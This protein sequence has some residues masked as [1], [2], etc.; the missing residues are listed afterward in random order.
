MPYVPQS[1]LP[2]SLSRLPWYTYGR[3]ESK[4]DFLQKWE[5][6]SVRVARLKERPLFSI[7]ILPNGSPADLRRTIDALISQSYP[8]WEAIVI[9][10]VPLTEGRVRSLEVPPDTSAA[11][12]KNL[13]AD[14]AQGVWLSFLTAGD[15]LSPVALFDVTC[16]AQQDTADVYYCNEV[17]TDSLYT[18]RLH[19]FSKPEASWFTQLHMDYIGTL[20]WVRR[21]L[22]SEIG[23]FSLAAQQD[24][25]FDFVLHLFER[26]VR[27]ELI[28]RF[29]FFHASPF[30]FQTKARHFQQRL[31]STH[32]ER[33]GLPAKT[34]LSNGSISITPE[35]VAPTSHLLSV[36]V[37]FKNKAD[38]TIRSL[39]AL[40]KQKGRVPVEVLLVDNASER[41]E[42]EKL[43]QFLQ[44]FE[45][46][47]RV[48][49]YPEAFNYAHMHNTTVERHVKG[50]FLLLLNNDVFL[51]GDQTLDVL[52]AWAQ[53]HWVGTVGIPLYF[54]DGEIQ[55]AAFQAIPGGD[56]RLAFIT[57]T[58]A[59]FVEQT[60][61]TFGS[62][63][64]ACLMKTS[65]FK[66]VGLEELKYPNAFGDVAFSFECRRKGLK[67]LYLA[68]LRATHLQSKS[69]G[70]NY[71]F[72]EEQA[73]ESKYSDVLQAML[74]RDLGLDRGSN[75]REATKNYVRGL[76]NRKLVTPRGVFRPL[77]WAI[78]KVPR[79]RSAL[80]H[81]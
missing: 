55:H 44:V 73:V 5:E 3:P 1:P 57:Q 34:H 16:M 63:F 12:A 27:F 59:D 58:R 23:G 40:S 69:R 79:L 66:E 81:S 75:S 42:R 7:I 9:G 41:T 22:W 78:R 72:W 21:K 15:V 52:V 62:S 74:R 28:P 61:E 43:D 68:C 26:K 8:F 29:H 50:D 56:H 25:S 80:T 47:A 45:L 64:A 39:K 30:S 76:I 77:A 24:H 13:A 4:S 70:P 14:K 37:C 67:N 53:F 32:L 46:T 48:I 20:W 71:E 38:L 49:D 31:L 54:P 60:R 6:E 18:R 10:K 65:T 19:T 11:A 35:I 51:E 33:M 2:A 17:Q 36:I